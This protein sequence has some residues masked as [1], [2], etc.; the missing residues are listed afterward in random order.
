MDIPRI[1]M[2]LLVICLATT[3]E[4]K[5]PKPTKKPDNNDSNDDGGETDD[6]S[7]DGTDDDTEEETDDD[8]DDNSGDSTYAVA[9]KALIDAGTCAS[10][11]TNDN[12]ADDAS[13]YYETFEYNGQRVIIVSG[14]PDHDAESELFIPKSEGGYFNPNTRCERWQ[15]SVV[16]LSPEKSD[17]TDWS[18]YEKYPF[19]GMG[20][21]GYA[22]SGGTFFDTRSSPTGD[23]A[24]NNEI[25]TL[26]TCMG[27]SNQALQY[28]YHGVPYCIPSDT[29]LANDPEVCQFVGYMLDGYPVYGRCQHT[30]GD[31]LESCWTS[32]SSDPTS[33]SDYTYG[34]T[35]SGNTCYLDEANGYD[36]TEGQTSDGYVG[37]AYV[38]TTGFSGVPIGFMGTEF[39]DIC[40][41]T[42]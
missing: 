34:S 36:F 8:S 35:E 17:S 40:G 22:T 7:D 18:S 11:E 25:E 12:C 29:W 13:G 10:V 16:P 1:L 27:H 33:L 20:A 31:E 21:Y 39:G 2:L 32:T 23:V 15:F 26:D 42:P 5:K 4:A 37:Y 30:N 19:Y 41:F 3:L 9:V 6:G 24:W 38:T 14:A 28:H